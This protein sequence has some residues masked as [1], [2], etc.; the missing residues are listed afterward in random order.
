MHMLTT[1]L[2]VLIDESLAQIL[3]SRARAEN[4]S[5]GDLVRRAVRKEYADGKDNEKLKRKKLVSK[6]LRHQKK[7]L[8]RF[9][10]LDYRALIENGRT[11]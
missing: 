7:Y 6:L 8:G 9:E 3:A 11:R 2:H 1:R 10:G 4:V 5:M